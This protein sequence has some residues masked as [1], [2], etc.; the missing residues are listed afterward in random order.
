MESS[1]N[2]ITLEPKDEEFEEKT[3]IE[4]GLKE[5]VSMD[6]TGAS[7]S[8]NPKNIRKSESSSVKEIQRKIE[9]ETTERENVVKLQPE[10]KTEEDIKIKLEPND[11]EDSQNELRE[12]IWLDSNLVVEQEFEE[13]EKT[14]I[15]KTESS[16]IKDI[17]RKIQNGEKTERENVV[18]PQQEIKLE[19]IDE[20]ELQSG[21]CEIIDTNLSIVKQ[22]SNPRKIKKTA[23]KRKKSHNC[24][25]C[26]LNFSQKSDL[27]KHIL[28]D[29][30][31]IKP[32]KCLSCE[33][34]F[35]RKFDLRFHIESVHEGKKPHKCS[36]CN[37]SFSKKCGLNIHIASVHERKKPFKCPSCE[38]SFSRKFDLRWHIE[39][40]HEGKK[41]H[42]C[43]K[44]DSSFSKKSSMKQHIATVHERKKTFKCPSCDSSFA[45]KIQL[46]IHI[47]SVHEG[48]KTV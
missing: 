37:S 47:A 20:E 7:C 19:P 15:V 44:C 39:S 43:T 18:K 42:K 27:K 5:M 26:S 34:R 40:V 9:S 3:K 25:L 31:G 10:I 21:P 13:K 2:K 17:Q 8:S 11:E 22:G 12:L 41:P 28:T 14:G 4:N 29:H 16:A 23:L 36:Q 32:F 46:S 24:N 35:L 6:F 30:A 48:K 45:Q 1:A 38:S 33:S